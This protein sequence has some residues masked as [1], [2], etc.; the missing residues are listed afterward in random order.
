MKKKKAKAT[1]MQFAKKAK[2]KDYMATA[3]WYYMFFVPSNLSLNEFFGD[4][5]FK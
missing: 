1:F 2:S 5:R 4:V 3:F